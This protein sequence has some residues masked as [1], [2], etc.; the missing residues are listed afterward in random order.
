MLPVLADA[1][2]A[3]AHV[4]LMFLGLP[5]SEWYVGGHDAVV[6]TFKSNFILK[7][8]TYLCISKK[9]SKLKE[10]KLNFCIFPF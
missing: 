7:S 10:K 3:I 9:Y 1:V 6:N 4:V 8:N 5:H 2:V